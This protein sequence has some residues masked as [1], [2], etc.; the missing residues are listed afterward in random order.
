M[1]VYKPPKYQMNTSTFILN[2]FSLN[3]IYMLRLA[4][5]MVYTKYSYEYYIYTSIYVLLY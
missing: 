2:R 1:C 5:M 3:K 4:Y